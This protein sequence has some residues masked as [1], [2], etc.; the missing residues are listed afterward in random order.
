MEERNQTWFTAFD[1]RCLRSY[2]ECP[3]KIQTATQNDLCQTFGLMPTLMAIPR[4]WVFEKTLYRYNMTAKMEHLFN[5]YAH[6]EEIHQRLCNQN[7]PR[8]DWPQSVCVH[9]WLEGRLDGDHT[10]FQQLVKNH[11]N[12]YPLHNHRKIIE[13]NKK[14]FNMVKWKNHEKSLKCGSHSWKNHWISYQMQNWPGMGKQNT[15]YFN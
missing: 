13:F 4:P 14:Y 12:L 5:V 3:L 1:I 11:R 15:L 7:E 9:S 8:C 6:I 10:G 2:H